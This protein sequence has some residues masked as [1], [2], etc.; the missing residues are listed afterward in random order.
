M[1]LPSVP[2]MG[3]SAVAVNGTDAQMIWELVAQISAP[4]DVLRRYAREW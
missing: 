2:I 1:S 4:A 3:G